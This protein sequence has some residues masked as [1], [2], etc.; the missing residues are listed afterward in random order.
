MFTSS[1]LYK[2]YVISHRHFFRL[3]QYFPNAKCTRKTLFNYFIS[4]ESAYVSIVI[5]N[6]AYIRAFATNEIVEEGFPCTFCVREVLWQSKKMAMTYNGA[7]T[8]NTST[9]TSL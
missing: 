8:N 3:P 7:M 4:R 2:L 1:L 5:V 6:N 9:T